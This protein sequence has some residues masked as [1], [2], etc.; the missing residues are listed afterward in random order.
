[1]MSCVLCASGYLTGSEDYF[2][3][4]RCYN[5]P[6]LNL[7]RCALDLRDGEE[8]VTAYKGVYSTELFSQKAISIIRKHNSSKVTLT[9]TLLL[10]CSDLF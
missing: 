2:T 8:A 3:H 5:I 1:M 9:H 7:T 10:N 4:H 6:Q